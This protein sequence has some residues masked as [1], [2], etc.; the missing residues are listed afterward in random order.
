MLARWRAAGL[1]WPALLTLVTLP[2]LI[3]LGTWQWQRLTWKQGLIAKLEARVKAEPVT[4]TAAL[5][6]VVQ[7]GDVEYLR[8]RV[9]GTFDHAEE[10]HLYAP[11][12]SSQGWNV[13]TLGWQGPAAARSARP[14][15]RAGL[16]AI[17]HRC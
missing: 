10:R 13:F 1:L 17:F 7:T 4:Y 14:R 2:V 15:E 6:Q 9:T 8:V 12:T 5:S 3:G 16:R 11:R